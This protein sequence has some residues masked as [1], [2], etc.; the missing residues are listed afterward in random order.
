[1][2]PPQW[3]L[4]YD[5]SWPPAALHI[6]VHPPHSVGPI[7]ATLA[8]GV[9]CTVLVVTSL[10]K[11]HK[12]LCPLSQPPRYIGPASGRLPTATIRSF[13]RYLLALRPSPSRTPSHGSAS[14]TGS[15]QV[16]PSR[17]LS[18]PPQQ[19]LRNA[20]VLRSL[21]GGLIAQAA[22]SPVARLLVHARVG[23]CCGRANASSGRRERRRAERAAS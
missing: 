19:K 2:T 16:Q 1:M 3:W 9:E 20:L 5:I 23:G 8:H 22:A 4:K 18:E 12:A 14:S 15:L 6:G 13:R 11:G 7:A 10:D 21:S 17:R